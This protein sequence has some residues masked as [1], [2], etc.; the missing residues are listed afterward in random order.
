[1]LKL[2]DLRPR[3]LDAV[4]HIYERNRALLFARSS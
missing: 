3:Q 4:Q 1:M 2:S